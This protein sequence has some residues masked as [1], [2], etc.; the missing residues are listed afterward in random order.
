VTQRPK[1]TL[2]K[3]IVS[4]FVTKVFVLF[5]G[6]ISTVIVAR[7]LGAEGRGL[8]AAALIYPQLLI[9][10]TEGG[11]RQAAVF[12]L[13]QKKAPEKQILG[14]LFG[15]IIFAGIGGMGLVYSLMVFF[16]QQKFSMVMMVVAAAILPTT[17]AVN[18]LKGIFL[19]KENIK[20]FNAA[21]WIQKVIYVGAIAVLYVID[22]LTVFSA[23]AVTL[24]AAVFNLGQSV[25]YL[26]NN[27]D[28]G[29]EFN[30]S[31]FKSMMKIGVV[32]ALALFF[33][34][35]NYK[36]DVLILSWLSEN[37]YL[38]QYAVAVQ[39]GELLWQLPAAVLV[40]LMSKSANA[41]DSSIIDSVC[42]TTRL[43]L[44]L[45]I[46]SSIGLSI[47]CYFA[48]EPV[49]G[50]EFDGAFLIMMVLIP[51]LI[52]ASIF[53]SLNAYYAGK[54]QPYFTIWIMGVAVVINIVL[55]FWFIPQYDAVG[56]AIASSFSYT[57]SAV[58]STYIFAK[59]ENV[60][61]RDI[62]FIY[63][64]DFSPLLKKLNLNRS[65]HRNN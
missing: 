61:Y 17:L 29:L 39:L 65:N 34:Q 5:V 8:L 16:G 26:K 7:A 4:V 24:M 57:I 13:G 35:A 59:R 52:L 2:L 32:Y 31:T 27:I 14:A 54:G 46:L 38:G 44:F 45:T 48:I 55:N 40:V 6:L 20:K 42:K 18:A 33:I 51:G 37:K 3:D 15:Y 60:C 21:T 43:T 1:S 64:S 11:M 23:V 12:F 10:I 47:I 22:S 58:G 19:G 63:W 50:E 41:T 25:W 53:K 36:V 28:F 62:L 30:L 9:A 56:A 49:F